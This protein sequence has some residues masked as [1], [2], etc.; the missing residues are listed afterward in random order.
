MRKY[1]VNN[2]KKVSPSFEYASILRW[3]S[4]ILIFFEENETL[5]R[6]SNNKENLNLNRKKEN[7]KI[8]SWENVA[9]SQIKG[10]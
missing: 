1:P 4:I 10:V 6:G 5:S 8:F 2:Q 7:R 9:E 3:A